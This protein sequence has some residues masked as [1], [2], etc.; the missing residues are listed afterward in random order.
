MLSNEL[1]KVSVAIT[2]YNEEDHIE[3]ALESLINQSYSSFEI[4]VVDDGSEDRTG[5][6]LADYE[7]SERIRVIY[8]N[9]IGRSGA[10]NTAIDKARGEYIA[11]VDP[12]DISEE[13]R[14]ELQ[15]EYLDQHPDVGI[16]GSAYVAQNKIRSESYVREYPTDDTDIRHAMA[17]YIPI[18][19]SSMMARRTALVRSGLYDGT[20]QAIVDLDLMIRVAANYKLAN[21]SEPLITRSIREESNFHAIFEPNKRHLQLCRLHLK[22]VHVLGLPQ[23]YYLYALGHLLYYYLPNS[24]KKQVRR[25][26]AGFTERKTTEEQ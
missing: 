12:D 17:K 1:V 11:I 9:H 6:I 22:A 24:V 18:P 23:H 13:N 3:D 16:V 10:L 20:R 26:F 25:S 19:H 4:V 15:A 7:D 5:E 21:L 2:T 14:L 8:S